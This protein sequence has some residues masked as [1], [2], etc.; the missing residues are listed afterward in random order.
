[1]SKTRGVN[2]TTS[3][4]NLERI[5]NRGG[6]SAD[7]GIHEPAPAELPTL[8]GPREWVLRVGW[9]WVDRP[10]EVAVTITRGRMAA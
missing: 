5:A 3:H 10:V 7:L 2:T 6:V 4:P 8:T 9:G 1:M